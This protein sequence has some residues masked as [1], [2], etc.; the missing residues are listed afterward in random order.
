MKLT[1]SEC[2]ELHPVSAWWLIR[3]ILRLAKLREEMRQ[4]E[5]TE[6]K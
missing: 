5:M 4:M 3:A 1:P 2:H 6:V